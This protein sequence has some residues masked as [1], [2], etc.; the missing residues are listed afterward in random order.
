MLPLYAT[1]LAPAEF[2]LAE[3]V[4]VV[5]DFAAL[6]S[7]GRLGIGIFKY[8]EAADTRERK[9]TVV[10]TA[11]ISACVTN[12]LA[13]LL[14]WALSPTLSGWMAAPR[15][16]SSGLRVLSV[17]LL[18]N[19]V[20]EVF[21]SYLRLTDR[22]VVYVAASV[23]RLIGQL[24][25]SILFIAHLGLGYWGIIYAA[26]ISSGALTLVFA[27]SLLPRVGL[28]FSGGYAAK[29]WTFSLPI[30]VASLGMYYVTLGNRYFLNLYHGLAAV[31]IYALAYK[32]GLTFLSLVWSPFATFWN[33]KQ[34]AYAR[35]P[36]AHRLFGTLFLYLNLILIPAAV[37]MTV[38]APHFL[39][40]FT[41]A[42]YAATAALVPWVVAA[43]LLQ[44]WTDYLRFGIFHSGKTLHMAYGTVV[45][46]ALITILY[47]WW[48]PLEGALGAAKATFVAFVLRLGYF[49]VVGNRFFRIEVPWGRLAVTSGVFLGVFL[50]LSS[51]PLP[52]RT[53]LLVKASVVLVITA[54][55]ASSPILPAE[56]RKLALQWLLR[57]RG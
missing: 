7:G 45:T 53:A 34:F 50:F 5:V 57:R 27:I 49:A 56:H 37:G 42:Q 13:M 17:T 47:E 43:S 33:T 16:F 44:C 32:F 10:S 21:F 8:Y 22:P 30:V 23:S 20:N 2:G 39:H 18:L 38:L 6:F 54:L 48:I 31:G 46:V 12:L 14:I 26:L 9:R 35:E 29:L 3:L 40:L 1:H 25:L 28:T 55:L 4:T 19:A 11:L 52:D 15:G 24:L 51:W 36:E 41:S